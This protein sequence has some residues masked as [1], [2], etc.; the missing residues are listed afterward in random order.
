MTV[1]TSKPE[2]VHRIRVWDVGVRLFHWSL[3]FMVAATYIFAEER[4][5]H[6]WLGYTVVALIG[7]RLIWGIVGTKH[8]RFT[9]FVPG[10]RQFFGYLR[11]M[12]RGREDRYLGHNPAGAAM[13]L[14]LLV[15]LVAVGTTGYMMG[16]DAYFGEEWVEDAHKVLVNLL[17]VLVVSH[18]AGVVFSSMRHRENL[19]ASMV[20][21][22]KDLSPDEPH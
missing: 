6:R 17:L 11:D 12:A 10:P 9:S 7:F 8:A 14:A 13:I 22:K 16:T 4:A 15:T 18:V 3:V 21:G 19:V 5:L 2:P 20:T 1:Y